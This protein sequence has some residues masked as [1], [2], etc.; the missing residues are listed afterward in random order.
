M[1]LPSKA[2]LT[3]PVLNGTIRKKDKWGEGHY[4]AS[5]GNRKHNG[6][7]IVAQLGKDVLSPIEGKVVRVSYPYASDLSYAGLLI[8]GLGVHKGI[9]V[10]IFYMKPSPNIVGKTVRPGQKIGSVQNLSPKY[11]GITNHIHI[12][13]KQ[14][15]LQ[16]NPQTL[17]K[18]IF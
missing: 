4:G 13:I 9:E 5:R 10:K 6:I 8:D 1:V 18:K 15:G 14:N 17:I 11:P 16:K 3:N 12:E 2:K 7:D